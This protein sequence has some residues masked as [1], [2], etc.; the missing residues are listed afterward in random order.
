MTQNLEL[1]VSP[2]GEK[3]FVASAKRSINIASANQNCCGDN[4]NHYNN[5]T[6]CYL[7]NSVVTVTNK[8]VTPTILVCYINKTFC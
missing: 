7:N 5:N 8:I 2:H 1:F 4:F 6:N 3:D